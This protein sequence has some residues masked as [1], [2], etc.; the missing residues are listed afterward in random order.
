M[1]RIAHFG[2]THI[3]NLKYHYEYRQAFE[4]IYQT[5]R[6]QD[7]DYI[8]HTGDLAHTKTQLSPEYFELA[9][10]F[11]KNL[12]DIAETHII[13]GNHDGNLRNSSRQDAIT[14]I[15]DALDHAS[16]MLHKYSGEVQLEDDLTINVLSIFDETNWQ[17][18]TD[19]EA[20]NI[21]LYH[22]AINNSKTDMGWIMDHGDHDIKVFD[23]F[24]YAMLGISTR[25][26]RCST[27]V[28]PSAIVVPLS[29]RI[30]AR[31]TTRA[32]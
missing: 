6:E 18:P 16:L 7:V 14:P 15:V 2:D 27:K 3:K 28:A 1:V 13:L 12:A 32:F 9:T 24:D 21:A 20:I 25:L 17:D 29:S 5:L 30:T 26:I 23:K 10:D 4:E 22:G 19:P 31:Q 8:V 11:L